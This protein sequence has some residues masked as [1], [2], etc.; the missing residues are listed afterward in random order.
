MR[1]LFALFL[2]SVACPAAATTLTFDVNPLP[3]SNA[4]LLPQEYGDRVVDATT[5]VL[6]SGAAAAGSYL[7]GS[8]GA[9]PNVTVEHDS[10]GDEVLWT[11]GYGDLVNV[12]WRAQSVIFTADT[13]FFVTFDS[14]D[15][16]CFGCSDGS[17]GPTVSLLD[18]GGNELW[19]TNGNITFADGGAHETITPVPTVT[20]SVIELVFNYA[21]T[22]VSADFV[23]I[24]NLRFSQ[25]VP[26]PPAVLLV[27]LAG[28]GLLRASRR[29]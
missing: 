3:V 6:G 12:S 24:D 4:Q 26:A 5:D 11:T 17:L 7:V 21:G 1:Y 8:E 29:G 2:M 20:A 18:G 23:G 22:E 15:I 25:E 10:T 16:A 13:G 14:F 19:S 28:L 27:G 9:T